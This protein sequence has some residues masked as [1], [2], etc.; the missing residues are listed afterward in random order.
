[1]L[2]TQGPFQSHLQ[3]VFCLDFES[4]RKQ[5]A[6]GETHTD[7]MNLRIRL[8]FGEKNVKKVLFSA[9]IILSFV[10]LSQQNAESKKDQHK[11]HK[12]LLCNSAF[13]AYKKPA[14]NQNHHKLKETHHEND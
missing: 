11:I 2:L 7:D 12:T 1:M 4:D 10:Y 8:D 5:N 3:V 13:F 9:F 6:E 14:F